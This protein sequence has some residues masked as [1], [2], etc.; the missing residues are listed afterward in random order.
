MF[1]GTYGNGVYKKHRDSTNWLAFNSG[2][3]NMSVTAVTASDD[4]IFAGTDGA[5]VMRS[6]AD[7]ASWAVT[8]VITS[9]H[10]TYV[11]TGPNE[12]NRIQ[13]MGSAKG[14]IVASFKSG[15]VASYDNGLTWERA[16]NQFNLPS[17][18]DYNRI[19]FLPSRI[20]VTTENNSLQSNS[21]SE[22]PIVDS[23][24]KVN[25]N[26]VNAPTSGFVN[27]HTI[28][29]NLSWTI[30]SSD[31]WVIP[32]INTGTW[33][34]SMS[35]QIAANTG[36]SRSATV[37]I[38]GEGTKSATVLVNQAANATFINSNTFDHSKFIVYPNPNNGVFNI[39]YD[40]EISITDLKVMDITG[41]TMNVDYQITENGVS[42][43]SNLSTGVY[44]IQINSG[45]AKSIKRIVIQ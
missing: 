10:F 19:A 23:I 29:S 5:G 35:L 38:K 3:T 37:T 4:K 28:T 34:S 36:T 25:E 41:R 11:P 8:S 15:L 44:F 22:L 30:T 18:S 32:S 6:N 43:N 20:F 1:L 2:L 7:V 13:D 21:M 24:V 27:F 9:T 42:V 40:S 17:Y 39:Q 16:G 26:I 45:N 12:F 14:Y 33:N 31:A